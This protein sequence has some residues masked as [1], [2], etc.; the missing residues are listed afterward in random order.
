[1]FWVLKRTV[2]LRQFFLV[3]T[4][5]VSVEIQEDYF[6]GTRLYM[7]LKITF[8]EVHVYKWIYGWKNLVLW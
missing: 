4:T 7:Y 6:Y 2:S 3:P 8:E 1:M 5:Y